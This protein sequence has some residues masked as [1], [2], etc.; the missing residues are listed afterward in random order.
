MSSN[1]PFGPH[2]G[3][4]H[5]AGGNP[6]YLGSGPVADGDGGSGS[7]KKWPVL[8]AAAAGVVAVVGLGG[9]GAYALLSGGG[10][11]PADAIPD[12]AVAYVSLNLDPS[13]SQKIEAFKILKKFPGI[14]KALD[15][16]S[17]DDLRRLV[18]EQIQGED[19]CKSLDYDKDIEPWIGERVALA[20]V[21]DDKPGFDAPVFALQVTDQDAA[22]TGIHALA[23]CGGAEDGYG[24]AFGDDYVLITDSDKR[25]E[26]LVADAAKGSLA[27][28]ESFQER[29]GKVGDPGIVTMYAGPGAPGYFAAMQDDLMGA[30]L[31]EEALS[32][33]PASDDTWVSYED[34][35]DPQTDRINE[36]MQSLYKD[37]KGMAVTVRFDDGAVEAELAGQGMPAGISSAQGSSGPNITELPSSTAAAFSIALPDGWLDTYLE[38]M[39]GILGDGRSMDQML[40]EAE[41]E[42]GLDLPEDIETL[43]GEGVSLSVDSEFDLDAMLEAEDPTQLPIGL[44]VSGDPDE[45]LA[46][47]EKVKAA[48]GPDG[49]MLIG[50][51][52][53]G[54]VAFGVNPDYIDTL[55]EGGSLGD[56]EAFQRV[57][58][59]ADKANGVLYVNF[60]ANGWAEELAQ[61]FADEFSDQPDTSAGENVA[62]LDALGISTWM[63]ADVQRGLCRLTTD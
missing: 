59:E 46:V 1:T 42:T 10:A 40:A 63:E 35:A 44:R 29:T 14:D 38:S 47:F 20:A 51:A 28:D 50:A 19:T 17:T 52:G 37:F 6:E 62:P 2:D 12:S 18:F 45:I 22:R 33:D 30:A 61:S 43:L 16:S 31:G 39:A 60:D 48:F 57:V 58:P 5:A 13:A 34:G 26:A 36:R 7:A 27:D 15:I 41:A 49:D 8:G 11:Q 32:L 54:V 21:P 55:L 56:E 53:D 25:A 9:W 23:K 4:D 3:S 24:F